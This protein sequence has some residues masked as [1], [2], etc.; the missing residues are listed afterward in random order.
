MPPAKKDDED[1]YY[2]HPCGGGTSGASSVL[3]CDPPLIVK[4]DVQKLLLICNIL[5]ITPE[6]DINAPSLLL[7]PFT[8]AAVA[9]DVGSQQWQC[10]RQATVAETEA[11]GAHNN[12]QTDGSNGHSNR[13]GGRGGGSRDGRS[14]GS[15]KGGARDLH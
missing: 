11:A 12:Q 10:W 6:K 9:N 13:N 15:G 1:E 2:R 14:R 4:I 7:L 8:I 5:N 3:L